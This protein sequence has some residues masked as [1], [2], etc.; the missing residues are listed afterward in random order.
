M[1]LRPDGIWLSLLI[2]GSMYLAYALQNVNYALYVVPLTA[3]IAFI[4]AVGRTPERS[5]AAHR[6]VATAI[7]GALAMVL[8]S[9]YVRGELRRIAQ[10]FLPRET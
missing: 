7:A 5:T 3:Y 1:V 4:L 8:H 9:L 2:V 10:S 6:V